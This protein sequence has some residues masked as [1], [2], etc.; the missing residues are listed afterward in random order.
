MLRFANWGDSESLQTLEVHPHR[1]H[2]DAG[3][4]AGKVCHDRVGDARRRQFSRK[5][6][7]RDVIFSAQFLPKKRPKI[8]HHMTSWNL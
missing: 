3:G 5:H 8:S 2:P 4:L 7:S 6:P 1:P